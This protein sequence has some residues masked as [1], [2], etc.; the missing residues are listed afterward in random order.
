[1]ER[2]PL[3]GAAAGAVS[4]A[5]QA[6]RSEEPGGGRDRIGLLPPRGESGGRRLGA[7]S[8]RGMA[9]ELSPAQARGEPPSRSFQ[10]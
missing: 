5:A 6:G 4:Q 1:M 3:A 8:G 2:A 9:G 7:A 10:G